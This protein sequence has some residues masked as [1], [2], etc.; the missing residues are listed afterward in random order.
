MK[1]QVLETNA[2]I[3][4]GDAR[5][6]G[7]WVGFASTVVFSLICLLAATRLM[8]QVDSS[9]IGGTVRDVAGAVIPNATIQIQNRDTGLARGSA[10]NSVG[11]YVLSQIPPG[12]YNVTAGAA[13]FSSETQTGVALG[14]SQS[15]TWTFRL[16]LDR[17]PRQLKFPRQPS[18]WIRPRLPSGRS[19]DSKTVT[20]LPPPGRNISNLLTLQS[21]RIANQRRSDRWSNSVGAY[22]PSIQGENNRSNV[23]LLDGVNNN[24]AVGGAQIITRFPTTF[25][26]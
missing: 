7:K 26:N 24:E 5:S 14:L 20:E 12:T 1:S 23:Y 21:R 6:F 18:P 8:A 19:L 15:T 9:Q 10:T 4:R 3:A 17:P 16:N 2:N 22:Y 13:G 25:R 11:I